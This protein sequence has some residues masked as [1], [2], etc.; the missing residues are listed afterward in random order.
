[1]GEIDYYGGNFPTGSTYYSNPDLANQLAGTLG[2]VSQ[3][4]GS[5]YFP[6]LQNVT[7]NPLYTSQLHG[8]LQS[9]QPSEQKATTGLQDM[10]R[11]A[12]M[13]NSGAF[14]Q[15]ASN[16][17][18]DILNNRTQAAGKLAGDSFN[19]LVAALNNPLS[20]SAPLI[21]AMKLQQSSQYQPPSSTGGGGAY[22]GGN[23]LDGTTGFNAQNDP[24]FQNA[25]AQSQGGSFLNGTS[26]SNANSDAYFRAALAQAQGGQRTPPPAGQQSGT[27][28][29]GQ[30]PNEP[31]P[32]G[33]QTPN[34]DFSGYG[35]Q[36]SQPAQSAGGTGDMG[37]FG[38]SG[39]ATVNG[40]PY[41]PDAYLGYNFNPNTTITDQ[42]VNGYGLTGSTTPAPYFSN[43]PDFESW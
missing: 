9:L 30:P 40:Q 19:S 43:V 28:N 16:L 21:N 7:Q 3:Q 35:L 22:G 27:A 6:L 4:A 13:T 20:Q 23:F 42:N 12:G 39:Q 5:Q 26:S 8:L 10:F 18:R 36:A 38:G 2:G 41:N 33:N 14:A 17:Q 25:L 37:Y 29:G 34:M 1:M 31:N 32:F 24:Y 15:Q 11:Q